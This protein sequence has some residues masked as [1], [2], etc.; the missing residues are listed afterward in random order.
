[1]MDLESTIRAN[2]VIVTPRVLPDL[3]LRLVTFEQDWWRAD[4]KD[5]EAI[6]IVDPYWAFCWPGGLALA[7]YLLDFPESVRGKRI[8]DL[9]SGCGV[10]A[11]AA[12]KAGAVAAVACDIDSLALWACAENAMLNGCELS[13]ESRD[14]IGQPLSGVDCVLIGDVTYSPELVGRILP[15]LERLRADG[16]TI[17]MADPQRGFLPPDLKPHAIVRVPTDLGDMPAVAS[18]AVPIYHLR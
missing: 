9:G 7:R 8:F 16:V 12:M 13:L 2:T 3:K 17:L 18:V 5:L 6:G 1:M 15:W 4:P 14:L 11:L 10:V